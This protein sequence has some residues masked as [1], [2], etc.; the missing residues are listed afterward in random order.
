MDFLTVYLHSRIEAL[1]EECDAIYELV[2][3]LPPSQK[4]EIEP[5]LKRLRKH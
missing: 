3:T 5:D 4:A 2:Q 1:T